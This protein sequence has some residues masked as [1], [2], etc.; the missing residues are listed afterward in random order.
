[1]PKRHHHSESQLNHLSVN[2]DPEHPVYREAVNE[3]QKRLRYM[4]DKHS[5]VFVGHLEFRF[6]PEME[7]QNDNRHI[8]NAI[9]KCRMKLKREGIDAQLVWAREQRDSEHPHYHCY[10]VCDGNMFAIVHRRNRRTTI[11]AYGFA[12]MGRMRKRN[13]IMPLTG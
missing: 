2:A 8:S 6:P 5:Q 11:P 3:I 12:G 13:C 9:R 4:T 1:M 7:T 10:P